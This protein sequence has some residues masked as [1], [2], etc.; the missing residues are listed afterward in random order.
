M[1]RVK[2]KVAIVTGGASG[3]GRATCLLLAKE[4]A[5]VAIADINDSAG[6]EVVSEIE[7]SGGSAQY[8]HM[9]VTNG[10]EVERTFADIHGKFG[11]INVL[12]NNAGISGVAKPTHEVEETEWDKIINVNLKG[13]FLCTK[14]A[15]PYMKKAG[16]GSI[17]NLSSFAGIVGIG[18][19]AP[20]HAAKGGVRLM[21]KTDAICYAKDKIRVNSV[22]P[23]SISTPLLEDFIRDFGGD[24]PEAFRKHLISMFPIGS[25]G[26]PND[27]AFGILYL[28]SDESKYVTGSELVIDGGYTA[29]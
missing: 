16:G 9:E 10:K 7:S 3:I 20:Y 11:K 5:K 13:V 26:E 29:Q 14:H 2:G 18:G 28:A 19:D 4:G 27:I 22:H 25:L 12:V 23:G 8:W 6:R 17:I 21:T 15:V 1:S 24:D